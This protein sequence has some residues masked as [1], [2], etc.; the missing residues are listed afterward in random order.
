MTDTKTVDEA[1]SRIMFPTAWRAH[2]EARRR[3]VAL[4]HG[5]T[6]ATDAMQKAIDSYPLECLAKA[7]AT[8]ADL[9]GAGEVTPDH[10]GKGTST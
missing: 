1:V 9:A 7:S 3:L 5:T 8:L 4:G 2:D 6:D 10:P